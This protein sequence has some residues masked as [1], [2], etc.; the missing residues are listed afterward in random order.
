MFGDVVGEGLVQPAE[1]RVSGVV[2]RIVQVEQP[3]LARLA[4]DECPVFLRGLSA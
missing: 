1:R 2:Q 3:D 4:D